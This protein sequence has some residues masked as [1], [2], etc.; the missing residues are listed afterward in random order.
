MKPPVDAPAS[1]QRRPATTRPPARTPPARPAS[2]WPPRE[3]Y[4]SPAGNRRVGRHHQRHIGG[5]ARSPPWWP[6]APDDA[7]RGRRRSAP[8]RG[9]ASAPGH[10]G[11]ARRRAGGV[12]APPVRPGRPDDCSARRTGVERGPQRVVRPLERREVLL[13]RRV[14]EPVDVGEHLVDGRHPGRR[15]LVRCR[16]P[17]LSTPPCPARRTPVGGTCSVMPE[18]YPDAVGRPGSVDPDP[19]R[20]GSPRRRGGPSPAAATAV[21]QASASCVCFASPST[22]SRPPSTRGT[23]RPARPPVPSLDASRP[24]RRSAVRS[25]PIH[26]GRSSD[27]AATTSSTELTPV[28]TSKESVP[29]SMRTGDVGVQTIAD[30]QRSS[31]ADPPTGLVEQ[32]ALRLARHDGSDPREVADQTD[33]HA[34]AGRQPVVGGQ[35]QVGVRRPPRAARS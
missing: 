28:I 35:R 15:R 7:T 1:R 8:R 26:V 10:G 14:V 2:L 23:P 27:P 12:A 13:Q 24:G 21:H 32:R 18:G 31:S 19:C 11:R 16:P 22:T 5:H 6:V 25:C 3:T 17:A 34:V 20:P 29:A 9:R 33:E 4:S 30:H